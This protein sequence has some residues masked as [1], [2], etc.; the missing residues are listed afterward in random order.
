MSRFVWVL[1]GALLVLGCLDSTSG[2]PGNEPLPEGDQ[3]TLLQTG[4]EL[5]KY[6][7]MGN[8]KSVEIS[9]F[10]SDNRMNARF[11]FVAG[12]IANERYSTV[13]V[14]SLY[15]DGSGKLDRIH[16]KY[17]SVGWP[18]KITY[19]RRHFLYQG[20]QLASFTDTVGE[21]FL[22]HRS[23][24]TTL[25]AQLKRTFEGGV[26]KEST[27]AIYGYPKNGIETK[28][29]LLYSYAESSA[30]DQSD[31]RLNVYMIDD[32]NR[33]G[34]IA[35]I[36]DFVYSYYRRDSTG[37]ADRTLKYS[38]SSGAARSEYTVK[39][40][41]T[42]GV[43]DS[44]INYAT[45]VDTWDLDGVR[46]IDLGKYEYRKINVRAEVKRIFQGQE[47]DVYSQLGN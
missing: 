37:M 31:F 18:D 34:D 36:N 7:T 17:W 28:E 41:F 19:H 11:E 45:V 25:E 9:T 35:V 3:D 20:P 46:I 38:S 14:D 2:N 39:R 43:A 6:D 21:V 13:K 47:Y 8:I 42:G 30:T 40:T 26:V 22:F 44:V 23:V 15:Y 32:P 24:Q 29:N 16:Y 27:F 4:S 1:T 33:Q 5:V 10:D 12:L